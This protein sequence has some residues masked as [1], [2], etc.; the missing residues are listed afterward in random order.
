MKKIEKIKL[1]DVHEFVENTKCLA[2]SF[3]G[4]DLER[5]IE[6][7][8]G[9]IDEYGKFGFNARIKGIYRFSEQLLNTKIIETSEFDIFLDSEVEIL[10]QMNR[11]IEYF[12]NDIEEESEEK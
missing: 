6:T 11:M 5:S 1:E 3:S 12:N 7:T 8:Y 2:R 10:E 9:Y 4:L